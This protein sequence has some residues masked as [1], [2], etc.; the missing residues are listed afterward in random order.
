M[1]NGPHIIEIVV[2]LIGFG[3]MTVIVWDLWKNEP[4]T[5]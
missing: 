5:A 3:M 4:P 2:T 1:P